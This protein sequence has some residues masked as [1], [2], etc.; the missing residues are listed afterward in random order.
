MRGVAVRVGECGVKVGVGGLEVAVAGKIVAEG[1]NKNV[2]AGGIVGER[3]GG[4]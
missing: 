4:F 2:S 3:A 1:T